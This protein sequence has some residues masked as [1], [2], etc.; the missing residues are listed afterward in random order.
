MRFHGNLAGGRGGL[1]GFEHAFDDR[2]QVDVLNVETDFSGRDPVH[3]Q[4]IVDQLGLHAGI[5]LDDFQT[6][7]EVLRADVSAAEQLGPAQDSVQ[8]RAYF[9][10]DI[11]QELVLEA[12]GGLGIGPRRRFRGQQRFALLLG[13]FHVGNVAHDFG[14]AD[15][16]VLR[17]G[18]GRDGQRDID[19]AAVLAT[20]NRFEVV[21]PFA[22]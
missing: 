18:D 6:L 2:C 20:A 5:A 21:D 1:H 4:E 8:W 14:G 11:G 15:N 16:F 13:A 9:V 12:V 10:G 3:V 17:V 7:L 22:A 19:L